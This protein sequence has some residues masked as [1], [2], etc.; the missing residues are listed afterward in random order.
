MVGDRGRRR[1]V[2]MRTLRIATTVPLFAVA[3]VAALYDRWTIAG[4]F[5]LGGALLA[6]VHWVTVRVLTR[7]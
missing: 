7:R 4:L 6:I 3:A 2:S 1:P 5:A